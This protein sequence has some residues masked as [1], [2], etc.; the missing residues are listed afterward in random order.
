MTATAPGEAADAAPG[1]PLIEVLART[2]R[3]LGCAAEDVPVGVWIADALRIGRVVEATG[4]E[5][6]L[7]LDPGYGARSWWRTLIAPPSF[8]LAILGPESRGGLD[9]GATG[10]VDLLGRIEL[11]WWDHIR[12]GDRVG[13]NLR[14]EGARWGPRWRG[15]DTI[16]V[17]SRAEYRAD[18][19]EVAGAIGTVRI[20][21]LRRGEL[22]V[23]REMHRYGEGDIARLAAHLD[24]DPGPRGSRPRF[25]EDVS[26]ADRLPEMTKGP[27]TWS[28][29]ITWI[30][31]EGR[32][33]IAGNLLREE[34]AEGPGSRRLN[35][36]TGWPVPDSRLLREDLQACREVGFPA[37]P[38]RPALLTAL[39]IQ[40]IT[41]WMGDD[42]FLRHLAVSLETPALYGDSILLS[43][44]VADKFTQRIGGRRY[45]A[46][47]LEVSG[48]NQLA[49]R[50]LHAGGLVFLPAR[51]HPVELPV[52]HTAPS[53]GR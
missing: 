10:V 41:T 42:A 13:A 36:V 6:P 48:T 7:F 39:V 49:E 1:P 46:V 15:R 12:L 51:G 34:P 32:A 44:Q 26:V 8:V 9:A 33:V 29:L 27:L 14:V 11:W 28:D 23:E 45:H 18:G 22:V 38:A 2:R 24:R 30:V 21:P 31:A 20:H 53:G 5:N 50:V 52:D 35:P 16:D 47:W 40:L 19:R 4:D 25:F 43:G 3:L 17:L 37:P